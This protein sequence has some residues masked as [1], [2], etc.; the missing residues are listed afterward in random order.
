MRHK[1]FKLAFVLGLLGLFL[2]LAFSG[3]CNYSSGGQRCPTCPTPNKGLHSTMTWELWKGDPSCVMGCP[4]PQ[5]A[6][7]GKGG[8]GAYVFTTSMDTRHRL[9]LN[10]DY[11]AVVGRNVKVT[12]HNEGAQYDYEKTKEVEKVTSGGPGGLST[13]N[14]FTTMTTPGTYPITITVE[15]SGPDLPQPVALR[16][17]IQLVVN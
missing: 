5:A 8:E 13:G 6:N 9:I 2:A 1:S 7:L 15:E 17:E 16:T 4:G 11:P 12:I 14:N 10:V 3:G